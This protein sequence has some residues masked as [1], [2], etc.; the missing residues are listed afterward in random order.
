MRHMQR[1][2]ELLSSMQF[3]VPKTP[4]ELT[5]IHDDSYG[6]DSRVAVCPYCH[7]SVVDYGKA[8]ECRNCGRIHVFQ[9]DLMKY[10]YKGKHQADEFLAKELKKLDDKIFIAPQPRP[11][12]AKSRLNHKKEKHTK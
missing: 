7:H 9:H 2:Q 12:I 1:A 8:L 6:P 3:G 5:K 10:A 11:P 4:F